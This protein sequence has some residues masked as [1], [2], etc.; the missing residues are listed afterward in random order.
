M[1]LLCTGAEWRR[2]KRK[3]EDRTHLT[4]VFT[5]AL[6]RLVSPNRI[7]FHT[8]ISWIQ[9]IIKSCSE[10]DM[11]PEN[12]AQWMREPSQSQQQVRSRFHVIKL[13][14]FFFSYYSLSCCLHNFPPAVVVFCAIV[15]KPRRT[16]KEEDEETFELSTRLFLFTVESWMLDSLVFVGCIAFFFCRSIDIYRETELKFL[17]AFLIVSARD[18]FWDAIW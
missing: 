14:F 4:L 9:W 7:A 2:N 8:R 1:C 15:T 12:D 5:T 10:R 16:L 3:K 13:T 11:R 6:S 18:N 17:N